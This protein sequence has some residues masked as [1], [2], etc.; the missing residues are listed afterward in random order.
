MRIIHKDLSKDE[1]K[2]KVETLD[3]LWHLSQVIEP[4]DVV[5]DVTYRRQQSKQDM[6]RSDKTEKIRIYL[7]IRVEKIEFSHYSDTLRLTG[8][9]VEGEQSG[10]YHTLNIEVRSTPKIIKHWKPHQLDRIKTAVESAND[11]QIL[12]VV[13]DEGESDFG[14]MKQYGI[15]F[16]ASISR[17]ISGKR[18]TSNR[19]REKDAF[20]KEVTNK[21]ASYLEESGISSVIVAGP[22]FVKEEFYSWV[23]ENMRALAPKL[24]I[25]S[26]SVTGKS[27]IWEVVKRGY[28]GDVCMESRVASEITLIETLFRKIV[29]DEAVYGLDAVRTAVENS[30]VEYILVTDELLRLSKNVQKLIEFAKRMR[31]KSYVISTSH[32]GGEKLRALGGLGAILRFKT[33]Y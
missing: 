14:V 17:N 1:L 24:H 22:G 19:K 27:G 28:V 30:Q 33:S 29:T 31:S 11:P 8:T 4:E 20:F 6:I 32:E 15:D 21:I 2:V 13:I 9:I 12:I 3:D 25:K 18:D 23:K 7:G 10:S 5:F 26:V 16:V